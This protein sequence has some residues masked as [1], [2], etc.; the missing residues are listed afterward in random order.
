MA[1]LLTDCTEVVIN[2]EYDSCYGFIVRTLFEIEKFRENKV[3]VN[4]FKGSLG[5]AKAYVRAA[6]RENL[7]GD[8]LITLT[9][10]YG[11]PLR[12]FKLKVS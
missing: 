8:I 5:P 9:S 12:M 11:A 7:K 2:P 4:K 3:V 10:A 1:N 6:D